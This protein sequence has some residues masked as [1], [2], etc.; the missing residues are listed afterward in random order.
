[1]PAICDIA[2][3]VVVYGRVQHGPRPDVP[4]VQRKDPALRRL[5]RRFD[6]C[7]AY[8]CV[9]VEV[10]ESRRQAVN[11]SQARSSRVGHP[12]SR[13]APCGAFRSRPAR[14]Q[15]SAARSTW[16]HRPVADRPTVYRKTGVQFPL[17]PP[18][19]L[20][21]TH[22]G[23]GTGLLIREC[24]VRI[25]GDP[26]NTSP[27]PTLAGQLPFKETH[28]GSIPAGLIFEV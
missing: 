28:A 7:R 24:R 4:V 15:P 16:G 23:R 10:E 25:P 1:M 22:L 26:P 20:G 13:I 11:L 14:P 6:S 21:R 19:H 3:T 17:T 12:T 5:K 9:V 27:S 18:F 2:N 8:L